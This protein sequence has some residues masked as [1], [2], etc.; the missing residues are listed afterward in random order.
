M[1][2]LRDPIVISGIGHVSPYGTTTDQFVDVLFQL[3]SQ[4]DLEKNKVMTKIGE[5]HA[6]LVSSDWNPQA[7]LGK[8]G[9]KFLNASSKYLMAATT[10]ALQDA[11]LSSESVNAEDL[12]IV[13]G[14][15]YTGLAASMEYD[16]TAITDGPRYVSPMQAP[17]TLANAPA[18]HLAIRMQAKACN[19]TIST[20]SC[21]GLDAVGYAMDLLKRNRAQYVIVGGV[22]ELNPSVMWY[23]KESGQIPQSVGGEQGIPYAPYSVGILPSEG[24]AS[25]I[26]ERKSSAIS[27]GREPLAELVSWENG[28]SAR[29]KE[30]HRISTISRV[31]T[32]AV[33]S[34]SLSLEDI[35]LIMSGANG[36]HVL[37]RVELFAISELYQK[38]SL[39]AN[40]VP[41]VYPIK[42]IVGEAFGASGLYQLL[43][44]IAALNKKQWPT[45]YDPASTQLDPSFKP[46]L[47]YDPEWQE[48]DRN[49]YA[50]LISHNQS[51]ETSVLFISSA[52]FTIREKEGIM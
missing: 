46:F 26:L 48:K 39:D 16:Q 27:R 20:G 44:V 32:S 25:V 36:N 38:E 10:L 6:L 5:D 28:F 11:Q 42:S 1:N 43:G 17:N 4:I 24:A 18:S 7:L 52:S 40:N 9:L 13:V 29:K 12:G 19:T 30:S 34:A 49:R 35:E 14:C 41:K 47:N 21:A 15:N 50:A 51:G 2:E 22:E 31:F 23:L 3:K 45:P 37:D 8:R 33:R